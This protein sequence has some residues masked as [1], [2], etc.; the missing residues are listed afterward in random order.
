MT[1][2]KCR[3]TAAFNTACLNV[4]T[5]A[6][7]FLCY[8]KAHEHVSFTIVRDALV[9]LGYDKA[10]ASGLAGGVGGSARERFETIVNGE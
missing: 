5:P 9:R 6:L 3:K 7:N 8:H 4:K 2:T 10:E 1:I